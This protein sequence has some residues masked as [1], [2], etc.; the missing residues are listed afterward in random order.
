MELSL[1]MAV[2]S[3]LSEIPGIGFFGDL[4]DAAVFL[5]PLCEVLI[6]M[7]DYFVDK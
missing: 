4:E 5:F 6:F 1:K 3:F 2:S 7:I